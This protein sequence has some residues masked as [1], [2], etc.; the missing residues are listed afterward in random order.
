MHRGV[1]A[2]ARQGAPAVATHV[3]ALL[4]WAGARRGNRLNRATDAAAADLRGYVSP[5]SC[6]KI[7]A[8]R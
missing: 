4:A 2:G 5:P 3:G 8:G 1:D 6:G 7:L